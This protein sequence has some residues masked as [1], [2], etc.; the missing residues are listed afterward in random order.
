VNVLIACEHS[1]TVRDAFARKG[2]DAWSCDLL[3]SDTPG[4]HLQCDVF[5]ALAALDWDLVIAHPPC[6]HLAVSGARWFPEKQKE[7]RE[8]L[9]FFLDILNADV[10]ML[11]VE[12]PVSI[13]GTHIRKPTQIIQPWMFGHEETK[14]TCLWLKNL[15]KL[16]P[17][18]VMKVRNRNLTP[19]GQNK[20]PPSEDRWK[21]RSKTYDGVAEAMADQWG[22]LDP[23][24]RE[25]LGIEFKNNFVRRPK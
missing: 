18:K 23:S 22:N 24:R 7:Q 14:T 6:T 16:K 13:I 12:N 3:P 19:S 1:G 5:E 25:G 9:Q 2:H 17:T 8:A 20:L 10:P 15:P 21:L 4:Q 11:C